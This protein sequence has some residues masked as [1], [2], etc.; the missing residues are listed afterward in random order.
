MKENNG[1]KKQNKYLEQ[2][3]VF[4]GEDVPVD[5]LSTDSC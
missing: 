2:N 3:K 4:F 5:F 1:K